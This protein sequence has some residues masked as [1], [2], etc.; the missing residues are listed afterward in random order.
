MKRIFASLVLCLVL[1]L[2]TLVG[3]QDTFT[4]ANPINMKPAYIV[5]D[6]QSPVS[7]RYS[8]NPIFLDFTVR[9]TNSFNLPIAYMIDENFPQNVTQRRCISLRE[10]RDDVN[11]YSPTG[12]YYDPYVEYVIG[13]N[14]T[15]PQLAQG[16]HNVTVAVYDHG[17]SEYLA[18]GWKNVTIY[19]YSSATVSFYVTADS[20]LLSYTPNPT[21]TPTPAPSTVPPTPIPRK[22]TDFTMWINQPIISAIICIIIILAIAS[23]PIIHLKLQSKA[24]FSHNQ[25][26]DSYESK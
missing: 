7:S 2:C 26:A 24:N 25:V 17:A 6:I 14:A 18:N 21:Q 3:I 15:L 19:E 22:I 10:I 16:W 9:S 5:I 13:G 1:L 8:Q 4:R 23:I 12:E 11:P 20:T